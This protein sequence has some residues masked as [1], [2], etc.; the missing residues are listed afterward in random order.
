MIW[1]CESIWCAYSRLQLWRAA[2]PYIGAAVAHK[3]GIVD[4]QAAS[5]HADGARSACCIVDEDGIQHSDI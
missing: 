1:G 5:C 3:R 4:C 2:G